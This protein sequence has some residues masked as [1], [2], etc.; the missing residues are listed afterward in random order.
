M[1]TSHI[2][3]W[4]VPLLAAGAIALSGCGQRSATNP[5]A[6]SYDQVGGCKMWAEPT[7][8]EQKARANELFAIFK[9]DSIDNSKPSG[10]FGFDPGRMY[11]NQSTEEQLEKNL[12]FQTR[13]FMVADPRFA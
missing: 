8:F 5:T 1:K 2:A 3:I 13:R 12:S 7:G 9:I 6:I 11:V 10:E 4:T